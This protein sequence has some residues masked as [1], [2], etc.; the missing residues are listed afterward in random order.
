[1]FGALPAG[2]CRVGGRDIFRCGWFYAT[3][4]VFDRIGQGSH[5]CDPAKENPARDMMYVP[6]QTVTK[7]SMGRNV[8]K[9]RTASG[10][11]WHLIQV[12][13]LASAASVAT[14]F[15]LVLIGLQF[16]AKQWIGLF[17]LLPFALMVYLVFDIYM[18]RR[19][20]VPVGEALAKLDEGE[21]PTKMEAS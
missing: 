3:G 10:L 11:L 14:T 4:S 1:T 8:P 18:I 15:F 7:M 9:A 13:V 19:H 20:Y 5:V 16:T 17:T 6:N 21:L 12:D 2:G